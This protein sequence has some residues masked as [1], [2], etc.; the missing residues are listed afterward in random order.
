MLKNSISTNKFA[1]LAGFL[2]RDGS[3]YVRMKPNKGY[4]FGFQIS[5]YI[6][7]FNLKKQGKNLKEFVP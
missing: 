2:D 5:P 6:V 1:Y 7:F 4:K 3:I